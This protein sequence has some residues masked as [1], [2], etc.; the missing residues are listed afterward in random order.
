M[1]EQADVLAEWFSK[2]GI[3]KAHVF[4]NSY[5]CQVAAQLTATYPHLVDRLILSGPTTDPQAKSVVHQGWRL[6][7]DGFYE[8]KG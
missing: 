6:Y 2:N 8:P 3:A 7:L 1:P 5:G 4:A